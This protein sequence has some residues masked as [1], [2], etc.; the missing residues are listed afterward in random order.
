MPRKK[1]TNREKVEQGLTKL[2]FGDV[3]DAVSLLFL[4]DEEALSRLPKR[5]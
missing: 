4:P 3:A 2:A 5:N 1:K